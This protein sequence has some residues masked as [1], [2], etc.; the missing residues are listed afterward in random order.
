MLRN[1]TNDKSFFI[2]LSKTYLSIKKVFRATNSD[3][4]SSWILWSGRICDPEPGQMSGKTFRIVPDLLKI[5]E[6]ATKLIENPLN[7]VNK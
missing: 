2:L 1:I 5:T 4:P 6:F 3:V 7:L